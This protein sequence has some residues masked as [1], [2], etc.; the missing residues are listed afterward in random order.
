MSLRSCSFFLG[1]PGIRVVFWAV[2]DKHCVLLA[3]TSTRLG[4]RVRNQMATLQNCDTAWRHHECAVIFAA[5][6]N[7]LLLGCQEVLPVG[8]CLSTA[9]GDA[10]LFRRFE[11]RIALGNEFLLSLALL[12]H[13]LLCCRLVVH[14]EEG[15]AQYLDDNFDV[16]RLQVAGSIQPGSI[17]L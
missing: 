15:R 4:G 3:H 10:A 6:F 5:V 16:H 17:W 7:V 9:V 12:P 13:L 14:L 8:W 2:E 11:L 1:A